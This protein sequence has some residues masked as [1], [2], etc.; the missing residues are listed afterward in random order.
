SGGNMTGVGTVAL[1][2]LGASKSEEAQGGCRTIEEVRLNLYRK[3]LKAPDTWASV[4]ASATY[5]W[6]YDT[7][8]MFNAG[9]KPWK[10]WA[11]I[12]QPV[13]IKAQDPAGYWET[14]GGH[15]MG[16]TLPGRILSTCWSILQLEVFY[17]YLPTFNI[18]NVAK[19][20][21]GEIANIDD[22]GAGV[23]ILE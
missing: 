4:A 12:F 19:N 5:G 7:Q 8:A 13:L 22:E 1:Q 15:G 17:R 16:P 10:R 14:A 23:I 18:G 3:V 11:K 21:G 2:L 6:Y 9:G 20:A